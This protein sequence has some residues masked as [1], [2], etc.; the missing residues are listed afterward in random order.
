MFNN[1]INSILYDAYTSV[2]SDSMHKASEEAKSTPDEAGVKNVTASFD[3]TWQRRGYSSFNGV[4]SCIVDGKVVD[5]AV[6]C[7]VCPGCKYWQYKEIAPAY[8]E[9]KRYHNCSINH[10]GSPGS[11]EVSGV[12]AMFL[13]SMSNRIQHTLE[14]EIAS[15][16]RKW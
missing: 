12:K 7:K 2:A 10:K 4:A 3:G 1:S 8:N 13:R 6:M 5:Y 16:I 15:H 11:M 9:W 14:M